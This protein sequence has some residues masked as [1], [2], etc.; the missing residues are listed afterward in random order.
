MKKHPIIV[1]I[2]HASTFVPKSI[3]EN[4][5]ISERDI[6]NHADLYTDKIYNVKNAHV[7]KAKIS[8]LIV[9]ANRAPDD[10]ETECRL[11]ADGV[12]VRT[13]PDGKVIYKSP[14]SIQ[15]ICKRIEKYHDTFHIELAKKIKQTNAKFFL[16][17][18]SMWSVGPKSLK[19]A[20]EKRADICLGNRDYTSCTRLQT[21]IIKNFFESHGFTVAINKP[22]RGRFI[23]GF[24][25]HRQKFPGIQVEFNRS[26]YLDEKTLLHKNDDINHL[27]NLIEKLVEIL[28][29]KI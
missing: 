27:N 10:I 12:I 8:R 18:H 3:M 22:Y 5:L 26:L 19:D 21:N 20:G 14:P 13:T 23:L 16:D 9:D 24:H 11:Q 29:D 2:P 17:G 7:F 15:S 28:G 6:K 25:C 1:S 4:M